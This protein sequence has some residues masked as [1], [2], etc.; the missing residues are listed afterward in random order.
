M[1]RPARAGAALLACASAAV[2]AGPPFVTDD[3][4]PVDYRH[5]EINTAATGAWHS[6]RASL[7]LPSVD[8]N[9]GA[10][11]NLQLHAQPRYSI[12]RDGDTRRGLDDTE[13]GVKYRLYERKADVASLMLGI[14]PMY[15]LSTGARRLGPDRGAKGMFLPVWAQYERGDWTAY[16]GWGYRINRGQDSRNS[17]FTGVTLL[18]KVAEGLQLGAEVFHE[19]PAAMDAASTAG[20]NVGGTKALTEQMALLFSL[21]GSHGDERSNLFYLGLQTRF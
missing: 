7:G 16:G 2:L 14:Y 19:T 1:M 21:G 5:W 8:I 20:F 17:T 13:V 15:Q 4:E 18:R 9:Y 12:E 3:P 11:P 10:A 6:G